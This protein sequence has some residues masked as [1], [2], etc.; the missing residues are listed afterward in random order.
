MWNKV[1]KYNHLEN[2]ILIY[3][4]DGKISYINDA[5]LLLFKYKNG[6]KPQ[7]IFD[8]MPLDQV[9]NHKTRILNEKSSMY[10]KD[11]LGLCFDKSY[12]KIDITIL[13]SKVLL[14]TESKE[15]ILQ[16]KNLF[17]GE[18]EDL[19]LTGY[20]EKCIETGK[21]TWSNGMKNL[22]EIED[23]NEANYSS[24]FKEND[25]IEFNTFI[26][27][28]VPFTGSYNITTHK[29]KIQKWI[30]TYC[31]L[32][33]KNKKQYFIGVVQDITK[34]YLIELNY[35]KQKELADEN[36]KIKSSF[37][38]SV[39]H[40]I[41]TPLNGIIGMVSLLKITNL[42]K[43]QKEY[44]NVLDNSCGVLL[45]II[46][47][48][49]DFSKIELGKMSVDMFPFELK[50]SLIKTIELFKPNALLKDV[51][52][53]YIVNTTDEKIIS[54]E[55]K[56]KQILSNILS[57]SIKFTKKGDIIIDIYTKENT[58]F[59][60]VTDTGIGMSSEFLKN[61]TCPFTQADSSTTRKF[62][63]SG[64]GLSI[65]NS[66]IEILKGNM[67]ITSEIN[68]GTEVLVSLPYIDYIN[69]EH[70]VIVE[71]NYANQYIL[72]E[73]IT[74]VTDKNIICYDNGRIAL[75]NITVDP[76]LIF[77]DLH[78]P[79]IDGHQTTVKLR[80]KGVKS[81]IIA[82]TANSMK[83]ERIR[84]IQSGMDDFLLKPID[85]ETIKNILQ[86]YLI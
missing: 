45:S 36:S 54:D 43:K 17:L 34:E 9:T 21:V 84:C 4:K 77:M 7:S 5:C 8:L 44:I 31:K 85:T 28:L 12:I 71:D 46:N 83:N 16:K 58:L 37:V 19:A 73:L 61:I 53:T 23:E 6:I 82:L 74:Q 59:I 13:P 33:V 1:S 11:I 42:E 24:C 3:K 64:L 48:I 65:V 39:S 70:I 41:R 62:G 76:I 27:N 38:S 10:N 20:W 14:I 2:G 22:F 63:G 86:K 80:E 47:N 35:K 75:E 57:N 25:L 60:K 72:K 55:V 52:L 26:Q 30:K 51:N 69:S 67:S 40:E 81:P 78:M 49:L 15:E 66:Y 50:N 18:M 68:K 32:T 79:E 29:N 56:I